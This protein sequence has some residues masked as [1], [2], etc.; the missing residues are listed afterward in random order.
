[1]K[2]C[3]VLIVPYM[4]FSQDEYYNTKQVLEDNYIQV[5]TAST[6]SGQ[7]VAHHPGSH[8]VTEQDTVTTHVDLVVSEIDP[9]SYQGIFLIGG[10]GSLSYLDVHPVYDK[11]VATRN[12]DLHYGAIGKA[13]RILAHADVISGK[14]ATGWN[15]DNHLPQIYAGSSC[16][17][18]NERVVVSDKLITAKSYAAEEFGKTI[19]NHVSWY[20]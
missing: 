14:S 19:A 1:M 10:P 20:T 15:D 7:A 4:D 16:A 8:V 9:L 6:Q 2:P 13:C 12:F 11:L 18:Q 17:Y 3:V 5:K